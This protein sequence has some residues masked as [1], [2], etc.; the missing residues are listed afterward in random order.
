M[1]D[2][3]INYPL[4][5]HI[6][7]SKDTVQSLLTA[8][9]DKYSIKHEFTDEHHCKLSGSGVSGQLQLKEDC[10]DISVQL[11]FFMLPFKSVIETELINKLN[12]KFGSDH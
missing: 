3:E 11:G 5:C 1:S 2:I 4:D 7:H 8:L 9:E 6:D 12:E 10:I